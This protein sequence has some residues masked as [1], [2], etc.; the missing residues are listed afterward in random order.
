MKA[1]KILV[2]ILVILL[3]VVTAA[4]I[5]RAILNYTTGKKLD[6]YLAAAKAQGVPLSVRDMIPACPDSDNGAKPWK[7]VEALFDLVLENRELTAKTIDDLFYGKEPDETA[8]GRLAALAEK[9]RK[10][11]DLIIEA[12][13][14]PCFRYSDWAKPSHNVEM[15]KAIKLIQ[16]VRLL[17]IDAV[18]RAD[19]GQVDQ[20]LEECRSGLRFV[21][22][23]MDEPSL[24]RV[25]IAMANT[26]VF[27]I[28]FDH[29]VQ[30]RDIA[31]AIL[32][33]WKDDLDSQSFR[34][35]FVK[36]IQGE[37]ALVLEDGFRLMEGKIDLF[38]DSETPGF[39]RRFY[40]WLIKP[41]LKSEMLWVQ[42][43]FGYYVEMAQLPYC[44]IGGLFQ[45]FTKEYGRRPWY[46]KTIG[47]LFPNLDAAFMKEGTLESMMLTARAGLACKIFNKEHGRYPSSLGELVPGL[48]DKVPIDPFTGKPLVYKVQNNEVLI[49]S[50]GSNQKDD[51]GRGTYKITQMVMDKDDDWAWREKMDV[52]GIK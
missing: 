18:L 41:V 6:H 28:S 35:E 34:S 49:Y 39:G 31:P 27:L 16:A 46:Y 25:L 2:R 3:V 11:L 1:R 32:S 30:G 42:K 52:A 20:A 5:L 10:A 22:K 43:L 21:M 9:H 37:R 24:L 40:Y 45:E 12:G 13:S 36:C 33:S 48:L 26:K 47:E 8:R 15:P 19:K 29:I 4:L 14:R 7:A 17:A 23:T 44:Q 50:L 51:G 38:G